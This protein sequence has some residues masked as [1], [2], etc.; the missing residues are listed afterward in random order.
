L[1]RSECLAHRP[2]GRCCGG[3]IPVAMQLYRKRAQI[4]RQG[5]LLGMPV[6]DV[7]IT[8]KGRLHLHAD[9]TDVALR[10]PADL[11]A[12]LLF[13]MIGAGLTAQQSASLSRRLTSPPSRSGPAA[14]PRASRATSSSRNVLSMRTRRRRSFHDSSHV[15]TFKLRPLTLLIDRAPAP[16]IYSVKPYRPRQP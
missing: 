16:I 2:S 1:L 7:R 5:P 10:T 12:F 9:A 3:Q 15:A 8:W 14:G 4:S 11:A 13:G 6:D